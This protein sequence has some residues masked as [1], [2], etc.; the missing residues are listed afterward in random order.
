MRVARRR[1]AWGEVGHHELLPIQT[2]Y[3]ET[4][5]ADA[6]TLL[7]CENYFLSVFFNEVSIKAMIISD[8][9]R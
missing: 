8:G 9:W 6:L 4:D 3:G 1:T 2:G 7:K 5:L